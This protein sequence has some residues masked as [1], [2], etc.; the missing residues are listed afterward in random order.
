MTC[1][2]VSTRA[3]VTANFV[4]ALPHDN[5]QSFDA[6]NALVT[7]ESGEWANEV[8]GKYGDQ[9]TPLSGYPKSITKNYPAIYSIFGAEHL[10]P[11]TCGDTKIP[12]VKEFAK[13]H[14][15]ERQTTLVSKIKNED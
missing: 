9:L 8:P 3:T 13:T 7:K 1:R 14:P 4:A 12:G 11:L 15:R 5:W 6:W 2:A 10:S